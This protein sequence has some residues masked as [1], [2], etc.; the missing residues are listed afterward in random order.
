MHFNIT[1]A[2]Y[3]IQSITNSFFTYKIK[4]EIKLINY[5]SKSYKMNISID[6]NRSFTLSDTIVQYKDM[7]GNIY[8]RISL[9]QQVF[10]RKYN[11]IERNVNSLCNSLCMNVVENNDTHEY[12]KITFMIDEEHLK[13]H[14]KLDT[15][16]PDLK[17]LVNIFD[18]IGIIN[19]ISNYRANNNADTNV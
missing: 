6:T 13:S 2:D 1:Y 10:N 11:K 3:K 7:N 14:F 16:I 17:I 15:T 5:D 19:R 8:Y 18:Q 12:D 4:N 9:I